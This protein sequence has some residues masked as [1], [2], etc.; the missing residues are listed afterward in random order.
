LIIAKLVGLALLATVIFWSTAWQIGSTILVAGLL[1][2]RFV[3]WL[4]GGLAVVC[5]FHG[6]AVT[7]LMFVLIAASTRFGVKP[8]QALMVTALGLS[9]LQ[10][11]P[12]IAWSAV[13]VGTALLL[14]F[15]RTR[16][17][18]IWAALAVNIAVAEMTSGYGLAFYTLAA[19]LIAYHEWPEELVVIFDGECGICNRIRVAWSRVDFDRLFTWSTYQSGAGS[20]WGLSDAQLKDSLHLVADSCWS[21]GFNAWKRMLLQ[22]PALYLLLGGLAIA[23]PAPWPKRAVIGVMFCFFFP[24]FAPIG[25]MFYRLFARNRHRFPGEGACAVEPKA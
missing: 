10:G 4:C 25:E 24:L 12:Q 8:L 11:Y 18:G 20:R 19:G 14:L 21:R 1:F 16:T 5:M 15:G 2:N 22:Q 3:P 17:A 9:A 23:V 13:F 6:E 7:A